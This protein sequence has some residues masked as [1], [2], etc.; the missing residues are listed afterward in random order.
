MSASASATLRLRIDGMTCAAC[1]NRVEKALA[2]VPGVEDARVNL[3]AERAEVVA[4]PAR[5]TVAVLAAAVERIGYGASPVEDVPTPGANDERVVL[6]RREF[7]VVLAAVVVTV[8]LVV[9]MLLHP[10]GVHVA[11]PPL[12]QLA[13]ASV[14][15]FALGARFYRGAWHALRSR[16]GTMDV[17]VAVG[18]TA[19]YGLSL[20]ELTGPRRDGAPVLYFEAAAV[21]ITLVLLGKWL[22]ARARR[23][24]ADAVRELLALRPERA[25]V[26]RDG[27]EIDVALAALRL[28]DR[29]VV[30]PGE[31]VPADGTIESGATELDESL[32]TGESLPVVREPGGAVVGGA[33]NGTGRIVVVATAVGADST[34]VRIARLVESAQSSKAPVQRLV[35]R[36]A[37]VFVPVVGAIALATFL[38]WWFGT[39]D[40]VRA[41]VPAVAVLVIACPCALGLATPAALVA[42]LGAAARGGVLIRDAETLERATRVRV[43]A[44]DKTGTLTEGRPALVASVAFDAPARG[45]DPAPDGTTHA[46]TGWNVAAALRV[47]AA[48]Q[49]GSEHPLARAVLAAAPAATAADDVRAVPGRGVAGRIDGVAWALG[50]ARHAADLGA[51]PAIAD[52]WCATDAGAGRTVA[53]LVDVDAKVVRAAFAFADSP[54]T[55][56]RDAIER[57]RAAGLRT[58][59]VTGDRAAAAR[60]VADALGIDRIVADVLPEDKVLA[61]GRLRDEFGPVAMVGDG[62]ND[63]PAL[64]AADLGIAMGSGTD[65][66]M[67]AAGVTLVRSDPL[68]VADALEIARR[69]HAKI[70]QNLFWAFAYNVAGLPLAAAGVLDPMIAG[71]AMALS[72]VSVVTNALALRRW[73]PRPPTR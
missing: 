22:E 7:R 33:L 5:V 49:S 24:T 23:R 71:A 55:T 1:V 59:M 13:L 36:V 11:L 12:V 26:L 58:V 27:V 19:A 44:F 47:A 63:A 20:W 38:G 16:T 61:I 8:P 65:V 72:S 2:R 30:R 50:S 46:G 69:T 35:D 43:V 28:G 56:A 53:F 14:V 3:A 52:A 9:P 21:V 66:A 64:A 73:R 60:R 25:R 37:A 40:L 39:G 70:R 34:L 57:L 31:R 41:I 10:F 48:L 29:V 68:A 42:G 45:P 17:L 67:H 15:Q 51:D 54:R 4:D 32:V 6:E 62:L 18:T